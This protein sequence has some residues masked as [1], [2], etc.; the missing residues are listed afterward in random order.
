MPRAAPARPGET[1]PIRVLLVDD[2]PDLVNITERVLKRSGMLVECAWDGITASDL[3]K[4]TEFDVVVSDVAMPGLDGLALLRAVRERDLDVP[5][6]LVTGAPDVQAASRAI[7]Y[8]AFRYLTKPMELAALCRLVE[9][10]AG[11]CRISRLNRQILALHGNGPQRP[12]DRGGLDASLDRALRSMRIV[13]QPVVEWRDHRV[14]AYE[15]LLRSHEPTLP[16]PEL[17]FEAAERA[18]RLAEIS[19]IVRSA[20]VEAAEHS[21]AE[22]TFV[23]IHPRDLLDDELYDRH[24]PLGRVA[25]RVALE[26]TER[27][28]LDEVRDLGPRIQSLRELGF[29]IAVDD[30]GAGYS[31]LT[32]FA[33]LEPE[34]VKIDMSLVRDIEREPMQSKLVSSLAALCKD[35]NRLVVAEGVETLDERDAL[36]ACGCDLLQ[37]YLFARPGPPFP[38]VS[39]NPPAP[40]PDVP[41]LEKTRHA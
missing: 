9:E 31:G 14:F 26:I 10:A 7:E 29:K 25:S 39:W 33:R 12:A 11:I 18:G 20:T 13:F 36:I 22:Y 21:D 40:S 38:A 2:N 24:T 30:L 19:R 1:R 16:T 4:R 15:A 34:I 17:L 32:S 28:R 27:A 37:G 41:P 3:V 35:T 8:G 5:V 23:N 6:I